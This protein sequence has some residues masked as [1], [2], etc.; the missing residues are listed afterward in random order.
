M[1]QI[2]I[3]FNLSAPTPQN[4]QTH[5]NIRRQGLALKGLIM[6]KISEVQQSVILVPGIFLFR[7]VF[8]IVKLGSQITGNCLTS[9]VNN[10]TSRLLSAYEVNDRMVDKFWKEFSDFFLTCSSKE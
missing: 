1:L 8:K 6:E 2:K 9:S 10:S 7:V 3:Y 4:G 5:S